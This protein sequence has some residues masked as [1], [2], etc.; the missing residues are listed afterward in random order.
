MFPEAG[1]GYSE[2]MLENNRRNPLAF[3]AETCSIF[4]AVDLTGVVWSFA[5]H[6]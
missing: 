1:L 2:G 3:S 5:G 6:I 4:P